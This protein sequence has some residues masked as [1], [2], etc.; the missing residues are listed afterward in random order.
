MQF[1][2]ANNDSDHFKRCEEYYK[3]AMT[4][5]CKLQTDFYNLEE[6]MTNCKEHLDKAEK[7]V[8]HIIE[9]RINRLD[10]KLEQVYVE[11]DFTQLVEEVK[12]LQIDA[13]SCSGH[14]NI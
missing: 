3:E 4:T 12:N 10:T 9:V 13:T 8:S 14:E 7:I 5:L 6:N 2:K 1:R 11:K